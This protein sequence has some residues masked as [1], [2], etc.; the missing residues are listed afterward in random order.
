L[1]RQI[2]AMFRPSLW[3]QAHFFS[4]R[5]LA[6]LLAG[7]GYGGLREDQAIFFPPVNSASLLTVLRRFEGMGRRFIPGGATFLVVAGRRTEI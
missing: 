1:G 2:K 5:E 3:R 4:L 6:G 7:A